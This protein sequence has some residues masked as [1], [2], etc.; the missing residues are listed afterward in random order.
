MNN[1]LPA[2]NIE[3]N[4]YLDDLPEETIKQTVAQLFIK[5]KEINCD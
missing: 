3:E 4:Y 2:K 5:K 1:Q